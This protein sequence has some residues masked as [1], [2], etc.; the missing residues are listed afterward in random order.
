MILP[1]AFDPDSRQP[2]FKFELTSTQGSKMYDTD[3][4]IRRWDNKILMTLF[5]DM[6]KMGQDQVGSYSLA[7]AK[8]NIMSLAIESRLKEIED[9][10]NTDLVPQ[11]FALNGYALD[12][13]LPKLCYG[14]LDRIDLEEYSKAIQRIFSVAA[15]EFDRPI[16]NRIRRALGVDEKAPE[17]EVDMSIVPNQATRA[18]DGMA[19]AGEGT[20]KSPSSRNTSTANTEHS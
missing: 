1:Q 9:V 2:L 5:A 15:I 6:L 16:A 4:I 11:L 13:E 10:L 20:S 7:G 19:T 8:T 18:G 3:A 14:E 12:E 17:A